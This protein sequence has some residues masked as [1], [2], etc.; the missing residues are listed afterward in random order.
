MEE[1]MEKISKKINPILKEME[2]KHCKN[3]GKKPCQ[4]PVLKPKFVHG[5]TTR[6]IYFKEKERF[7]PGAVPIKF[8]DSIDISNKDY[9]K[10]GGKEHQKIL[11]HGIH[12]NGKSFGLQYF[13]EKYSIYKWMI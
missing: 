9:F 1:L 7:D 11:C 5:L 10:Y 6:Y 2:K 13:T 4:L 3:Q 8:F 12:G